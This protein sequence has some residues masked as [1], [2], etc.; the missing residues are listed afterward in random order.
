MQRRAGHFVWRELNTPNLDESKAF[1]GGL[2]GWTIVDTDVA[3]GD[4]TFTMPMI[5][6]GDDVIGAMIPTGGDGEHPP[7][8]MPY[9]SVDDVD[10]AAAAAKEAGGKVGVEP[11]DL[12]RGRF[13]V[14]GDPSGAWITAYANKAGDADAKERP[15]VGDFCWETLVS[16]DLD[17]AKP[18]YKAVFGWTP[19][20]GPMGTEAV[21]DAA[22]G[23][24]VADF[25]QSN[26]GMPSAWFT[27]VVVE[28]L[29]DAKAKAEALGA[30][31]Q[32]P[33]VH[34]PGVGHIALIAD[35]HGAALGLFQ[36]DM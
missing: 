27:Y 4:S 19:V 15:D 7:H 20:T 36:P 6:N 32:M 8:W 22:D 33:H 13:S 26:S 18:F 35:P 30:K 34:I 28:N 10:A 25:Q 23:T 21:F 9:V 5:G 12:P 3:M 1:Y 16:Q 31:V 24:G 2:F 14:V 17:A 11:F 29:D